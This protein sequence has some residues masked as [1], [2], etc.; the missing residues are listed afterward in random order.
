MAQGYSIKITRENDLLTVWAIGTD[1]TGT[2]YTGLD[3]AETITNDGIKGIK[4]V[5]A[6]PYIVNAA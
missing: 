3:L 5:E 6:K 1:V 4:E 2:V